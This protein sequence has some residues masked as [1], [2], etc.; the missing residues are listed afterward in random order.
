MNYYG[1]LLIVFLAS[2]KGC[3][4]FHKKSLNSDRESSLNKVA[5]IFHSE[6]GYYDSTE[7]FCRKYRHKGSGDDTLLPYNLLSHYDFPI[8]QERYKITGFSFSTHQIK[9]Y[10]LSKVSILS[11][12]FQLGYVC[13]LKDTNGVMDTIGIANNS[14]KELFINGRM[15][16][17]K[18]D[19]VDSL[20][21]KKILIYRGCGELVIKPRKRN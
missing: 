13:I 12:P 7:V 2:T 19:I 1:C 20:F 11:T 4:V 3:D 17:F 15:Y 18:E 6:S 10:I 21:C 14:N 5:I 16:Y 8:W 9:R